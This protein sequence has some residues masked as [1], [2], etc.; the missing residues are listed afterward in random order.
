MKIGEFTEVFKPVYDGVARVVNAYADIM[1]KR[2]NEV[3][4]ITPMDNTGYRGNLGYEIVD[5][6]A[7]NFSKS[8]PWKI[9]IDELD[10]HFIRRM[11]MID[12]DIVHVHGP[13]FAGQAGIHYA[14]KHEIPVIGTFHSRFYDD[15]L[16]T[17]HSRTL[18]KIA[19]KYVADFYEK[20]DEVW[21]VSEGA[22]EE[23][24]RYG[25]KGK[26][27]VMQ[28]GTNMRTVNE[29]KIPEVREKYKL[30]SDV[31]MFLFVGQINRKKGLENI[32]KACSLLR[33]DGQDFRLVLA[34]RGPDE[35]YVRELSRSTGLDDNLIMTGHLD[36][37]EELDCLYSMAQ[38]F[39]F[40]SLYDNSPM[41]VREAACMHTPSV[42]VKGS[43]S[44]EVITDRQNG[45]LCENTP[46]DLYRQ[47][48]WYNTLPETGK[49]EIKENAYMTIPVKW[50]GPLMDTILAR[51]QNL[52]DT[53]QLQK[54]LLRRN[55]YG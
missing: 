10:P 33:N 8:M 55:I 46:E 27:I 16:K 25:Y 23:L 39:L 44:A 9:G 54:N 40:P 48:K 42:L 26:I 1:S 37:F 53:N 50:D 43:S 47:I 51:Y 17:T 28:N 32:I 13:A 19:S 31:P 14:L 41:V 11:K 29:K 22:G 52:V 18:A 34:G 45:L 21:A 38:L 2:G 5:Y 24:I 6:D 49:T 30:P 35:T 20:C 3:Y 7:V 36:D 4:V 15:V 12:L